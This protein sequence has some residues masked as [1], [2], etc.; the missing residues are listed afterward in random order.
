MLEYIYFRNTVPGN[1]SCKNCTCMW[2][3][4]REKLSLKEVGVDSRV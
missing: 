4:Q 2:H 1:S 3:A